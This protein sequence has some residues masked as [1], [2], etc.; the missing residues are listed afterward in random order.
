[1]PLKFL[2][3][4][5]AL[6]IP[7]TSATAQTRMVRLDE[8]ART[9]AVRNFNTTATVDIGGFIFCRAGDRWDEKASLLVEVP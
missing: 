6:L 5:L 2:T 9:A 3:P 4:L 1:M 8:V 7:A